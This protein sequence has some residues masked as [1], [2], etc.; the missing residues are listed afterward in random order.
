MLSRNGFVQTLVAAALQSRL[1]FRLE[2]FMPFRKP[3]RV[4]ASVLCASRAGDIQH[5]ARSPST[6]APSCLPGAHPGSIAQAAHGRARLVWRA[7][8]RGPARVATQ[9]VVPA[10]VAREPPQEVQTREL[11][12]NLLAARPRQRV[13]PPARPS[14]ARLRRAAGQGAAPWPLAPAWRRYHPGPRHLR[15]SPP[16]PGL[17]RHPASASGATTRAPR[18]ARVALHS[19]PPPDESGARQQ[20]SWP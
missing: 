16:A 18:R 12:H 1:L 5:T 3:A 19:G 20:S 4:H 9:R 11:L 10:H 14:R 15:L 6:R 2:V 13:N 17:A 7:C 8:R